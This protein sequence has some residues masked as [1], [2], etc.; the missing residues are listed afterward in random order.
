M[1]DGDDT[2][3]ADDHAMDGTPAA[4]SEDSELLTADSSEENDSEDD[5]FEDLD[6]GAG[7]TEIWEH[8]SKQRGN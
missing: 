7:C 2:S 5:Q 4:E 3:D 6:A 8:L 1:T